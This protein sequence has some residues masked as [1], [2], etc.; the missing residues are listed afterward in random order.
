MGFVANFTQFPAVQEFWKSV[1][2]WQ[3]YRQFK[4]GNFFL[5]HSADEEW[6]RSSKW[7]PV[8]CTR[9]DERDNQVHV[10][11]SVCW[12]HT[13]SRLWLISA[14]SILLCLSALTASEARSL[15]ARSINVNL[16][17]PHTH[18]VTQATHTQATH[19]YRS[20]THR[21]RAHKQRSVL[22][23]GYKHF[24]QYCREFQTPITIALTTF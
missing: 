5:R 14:P 12:W 3:S 16:H 15:P 18:T 11:V 6:M 20:H 10:C 13:A 9:H 4:G 24:T 7:F 23:T 22:H 1:K 17:R 8:H 21:L 19:T 2:I